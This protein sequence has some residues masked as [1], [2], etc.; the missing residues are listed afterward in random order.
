METRFAP[1][2]LYAALFCSCYAAPRLELRPP[3]GGCEFVREQDFLTS[4]L[5][6]GGFLESLGFYLSPGTP[7][8][9]AES[10]GSGGGAKRWGRVQ[11]ETRIEFFSSWEFEKGFG[12]ILLSR[13]WYVPREDALAGRTNAELAD[14]LA[15]RETLVPLA[16]M[17]PPFVALAVGGKTADQADYPLVRAAGIR[18]TTRKPSGGD[19]LPG[20]FGEKLRAQKIE[21]AYTNALP[22]IQALE[23]ALR[24]AEKPLAQGP[25]E[26][27]WIAAGGDLMLDR[28][29][30][31]ILFAEG[32]A[33]IFGAT[34]ELLA[35]A[36]L[37]LVNLE[38]AV[39]SRGAKVKK[40]FNFRF[41]PRVAPALR[42]AG[43]DGVLL[44][45][46]HAFDYGEEAFQDSLSCL[47]AAG[48]AVL[49]AGLNNE[50]A[51]RPFLF[52]KGGQTARVFGIA[53][54][55][56]EKNGWDGLTVAARAEKAGLLHARLGGGE[57][58]KIHFTPDN[59]TGDSPGIIDVVLFHGG[60]EWAGRPDAFTREFYTD[61]IQNGADLVI[62]SHPHVVQGFEW[63][64]GKPV[65]WS[66]GNYVFGGMENTGGGEEGLFVRLGFCGGRLVYL[67][68]FA[69]TLS[70]TRTRIA[71]A[72]RLN[73]FYARS[74]ELRD[75]VSGEHLIAR[76]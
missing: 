28:G 64:L 35:Q 67:E 68:P 20:A 62:G 24:A 49:G 56:R 51:A 45:N 43:I 69:L 41:D 23:E 6:E 58:L 2:L 11:P 73:R 31:D 37:A 26:I 27:L 66:L 32:P 18:I 47:A 14:C 19:F 10:G 54:F 72:T 4:L 42:D 74:R 36:D 16:G 1:A 33:G 63:V 48:I 59:E 3:N 55:F 60:I 46:N 75:T 40:S 12:D 38:G 29:A 15:G 61:L 30:A 5:T 53:S 52:Q 70:H 8:G 76:P 65:F 22:K 34:A 50:N 13:D 25:P 9:Q 17:A 44:A 39:S 21:K 71:P 7:G 57:N